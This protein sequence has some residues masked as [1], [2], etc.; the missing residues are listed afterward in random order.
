M[1]FIFCFLPQIK[2]VRHFKLENSV[3]KSISCSSYDEF[4]SLAVT[5]TLVEII[6]DSD[7]SEKSVKGI[8]EDVFSKNGGEFI[9]I[10]S[11]EIIRLDAILSVNG[12]Q[13]IQSC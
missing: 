11:G 10:N 12:K 9:K 13:I 7:N 2:K 4:E 5:K 8:I 1:T 3:Y 6:Y